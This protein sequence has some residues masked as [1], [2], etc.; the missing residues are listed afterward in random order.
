MIQGVYAVEYNRKIAVKT[1]EMRLEGDVSA[2]I[3]PGQFANFALEGKYLR[4]PL[5]VCD[6]DEDGFSVI[7]KV[8]GEGTAQL[9][10][11]ERGDMLDVLTGLGNG[12]DTD[13]IPDGAVLVGGGAGVPPMY[14]LAKALVAE[15]KRVFAVLGFNNADEV[16]YEKEF[17]ELGITP[18]ITTVDGSKGL[19]GF[20][21]DAFAADTQYVC[22]CGPEQMLKAVYNKCK[23]G[24]FSFEARMGCGFG[25][26]M[27]CT[28]KTKYGA[29]RICV[30]GP[31][32]SRGE[33]I[34]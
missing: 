14:G 18:V 28:C 9:S 4:R 7:Y 10:A 21:T 13:A 11:M 29:K 22:A 33:I 16:F 30:D 32:L 24:Q 19:K 31:V 23:D 2:F 5:S 26:C 27:G 34:W 25:A 6:W 8:I 15:D 17:A 1:Y 20:V 12:Y 3:R